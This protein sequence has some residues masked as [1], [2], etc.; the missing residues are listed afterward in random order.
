MEEEVN[1]E[2]TKGFKSAFNSKGYLGYNW[3]VIED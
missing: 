2:Y 1:Q 3:K